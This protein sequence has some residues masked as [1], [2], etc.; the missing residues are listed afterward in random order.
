MQDIIID[1]KFKFLLPEL[2]EV[3][4]R[5]LETNILKHGWHGHFYE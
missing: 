5:D 4:Y 2:D 1:E 3:T